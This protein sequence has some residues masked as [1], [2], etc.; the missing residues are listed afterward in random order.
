[1]SHPF[2]ENTDKPFTYEHFIKTVKE[3]MGSLP[4]S[5]KGN[6]TT[7]QMSDAALSAFSTFFM[8]SPSFLAQQR[9]LQKQ[10]SQNNVQ[11]L[12]GVYKVPSDNQIR[13]LMDTVSPDH[14]YPVYRFI[15]SA[16][17]DSGYFEDF[18][19]LDN[20]LL[21]ALDGTEY[22]SSKTIHCDC[23]STTTSK[24][25]VVRYHHNAVTPVIV[26]PHK[27][28]VIPLSPEFIIPQDGEDK[29]DCEINASKRWVEREAE[30]YQGQNITILGDDLYCHEPFC[31]MLLAKNWNF[32]FV[33]KPSSHKEVYDHVDGLSRIGKVHH[34]RQNQWNGKERLHYHYRY[35]NDVPIKDGQ[36]ALW[37]NWCEITIYNEQGEQCYKNSFATN[38]KVTEKNVVDIVRAGRSRWKIEN[39]NNN[40]LKTKG[41]HLEHNFGH[42]KQ[43]LASTLATLNI[44]SFLIHTVLDYFDERYR[45]IQKELG[46][47]KTFFNDIRALTRYICFDSWQQLL[48][49][50][51]KGLEIPIPPS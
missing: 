7:Y 32:I 12:F 14:F 41:Y 21:L 36:Q 45:L 24:K 31:E 1:M 9:M 17:M 16:L 40:T 3:C 49:T 51:M 44:L 6:N 48:E 37:V 28:H 50:M 46:S 47:R 29:Q 2:E 13:N 20:Q 42:G 11:S 38:H 23:C 5:R 8:Q 10:Q 4:D 43:H 33:C 15:A 39:E 30:A 22:F 35:L 34:Y 26:S 18:K 19:V 25:G 27:S